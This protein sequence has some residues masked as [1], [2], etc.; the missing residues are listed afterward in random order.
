[1]ASSVERI[2]SD[3][4]SREKQYLTFHR[5]RRETYGIDTREECIDTEGISLGPDADYDFSTLKRATLDGLD[6]NNNDQL[7]ELSNSYL[8]LAQAV[9]QNLASESDAEYHTFQD[10][11][12]TITKHS[13]ESTKG[14]I[15]LEHYETDD[16]RREKLIMC[17]TEARLNSDMRLV[18]HQPISFAI[19]MFN[20]EF[21]IRYRP[22]ADNQKPVIVDYTKDTILRKSQGETHE[23]IE[24]L[25]EAFE[26]LVL[27]ANAPLHERRVQDS[28]L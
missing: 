20:G 2:S 1:M 18:Q 22:R 11:F 24:A 5:W 10:S 25:N 27:Y 28:N 15:S 17:V 12:T 23:V 9:I 4:T 8:T 3:L 6:L 13:L 26:V 7:A 14:L 19:Q 21:S 16:D